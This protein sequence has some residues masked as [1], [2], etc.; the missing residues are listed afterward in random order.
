M[1]KFLKNSIKIWSLLL[2]ISSSLALAETLSTT[3]SF[4]VH[5][6]D[7]T[8]YIKD[9]TAPWLVPNEVIAPSLTLTAPYKT[10]FTNVS[11]QG[12]ASLNWT[13]NS[14]NNVWVFDGQT[15]GVTLYADT[16][17]INDT[18]TLNVDGNKIT[19]R[20]DITCQNFALTMPGQWKVHGQ[21]PMSW[22]GG[23]LSAPLQGL[24]L[25]PS[26]QMPT[27]S[28]GSCTGGTGIQN[29]IN[30]LIAA[31]F[32]NPSGMQASLNT[33]LQNFINS[34]VAN[35]MAMM[36]K[37]VSFD[38]LGAK[39]AFTPSVGQNLTSGTWVIDGPLVFSGPQGT[40]SKTIAQG[41]S[42]A[43]MTDARASGF[44]F[45]NALWPE[46]M[47][48][49]SR[50]GL[51]TVKE[52]SSSIAAFQSFMNNRM[53]QFFV[54]SDLMNFP[55][56]QPFN[57]TF[58]ATSTP[59]IQS[60]TNTFPG[61][62]WNVAS[63]L[64]VQMDAVYSNGAVP[65]TQFTSNTPASVQLSAKAVKG[66]LNVTYSITNLDMAY[67]FRREFLK[68]RQP[69][70]GIG[71]GPIDQAVQSAETNQTWSYTM[72]DSASPLPG[73]RILFSDLIFGKKTFRLEMGIQ[74]K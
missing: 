8:Q 51:F 47:G 29:Y 5:E 9:Q 1:R 72:P 23:Q 34:Q 68:I 42:I 65:Y 40:G 49:A 36:G 19:V 66:A 63:P 59:Q 54:W 56:T 39:V 12:N 31:Q 16:F 58:Q 50:G 43:N 10:T 41:Y 21:V 6:K 15:T 32:S 20:L 30:Q 17:A 69:A 48:F 11:W 22:S 7:I 37:P 35:I 60:Q 13:K 18:I 46:I 73:Y 14:T 71:M 24:T 28:V 57:F 25:T 3:G 44:A 55:V 62:Q 53:E 33:G 74:K 64:Y 4:V 2:A 26:S 61:V 52:P 27:V 67:A 45:N 70:F 38:V